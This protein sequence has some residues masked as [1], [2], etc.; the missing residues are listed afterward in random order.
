MSKPVKSIPLIR[1]SGFERT[2][3]RRVQGEVYFDEG[4]LGIYATDASSYQITPVAVCVPKDEQD[5]LAALKTANEFGVTILARGGGT[6][7]AGQA[8]GQSLV[9]DF[10]KHMNKVLEL[11]VEQRWVRVQPGLV[12]D[13]LNALLA[14]HKL[15]YAIDP[16]TANR[17]NIG[18]IVANN[19][20]GTKSILYGKA[21]EHLIA[22]KV[23]L[24]D[25]TVM[26]LRAR[27]MED[28]EV[29]ASQDTREGEIHRG[30]Y[31]IIERNREEIARRW[32]KVMRCVQGYNLNAFIQPG[33]D[34]NLAQL[35][36]GSEG[37]LAT[38]LE[39]TIN[40]EPL[41]KA[42][43]IC[44]P[45]FTSV[46]DAIRAT[47]DILPFNPSAVE[48]LDGYTLQLGYGNL[49]VRRDM[50]WMVGDVPGAVLICEFYGDT[51]ED[52]L[53]RAEAMAASL[54]A[55]GKG[56][57]YPIC[58]AA[59]DQEK[60]WNVRKN[61]L[62]LMMGVKGRRKPMPLI[63][64]AAI[65]VENLADY[66]DK[67]LVILKQRNVDVVL[68]AH[69]SVGVLH[70]RPILDLRDA[71][72]LELMKEISNAVFELVMQYGGAFS[73]EHGDG[74]V[75]S[76]YMERFYGPQ[77]YQA[78]HEVKKLFDPQWRMNPGKKV[79]APPID[80]N[81]RFGTQYDAPEP[82]TIYHYREI[83]SFTEAVHL[84]TGVGACRKTLGGTMCPSYMVTRDEEHSTRGRG[85]I[86]RLAMSGQ[87]GPE[88]MSSDRVYEALDLCL[89]C[90]GCKAEC[91][92]NVDMAKLKSEFLQ[93]YRDKHGIT[94]RDRIIGD[95]PRAAALTAGPLAPFFNWAQELAPIR[96]LLESKAG[97]DRRRPLPRV[98]S[99]TFATWF[100]KR[101]DGLKAPDRPVAL[102]CDTYLN[103]Y[104]PHIGRAAVALLESCGYE[105]QLAEVGCCQRPRISHGLLRQAKA[106]GMNTL[107]GIAQ[108]VARDIPVVAIE[109]SCASALTDD[110]P[111]MAEDEALGSA[112][113]RGV[114]II[115]QFLACEYE[116]GRIAGFKTDQPGI[117]LHGHCHQK[118]LYSTQG[119]T[120]LLE[121]AGVPTREVDSG[122]CGMAG[123]FGYEKEHY[124]LSVRAGER[125]LMPAIRDRAAGTAVVAC[126]FSCR[127]QIR[128]L[129]DT[130]ALHWVE[131]LRGTGRA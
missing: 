23:A 63:E 124:E 95:S 121:A 105:V 26:N 10:S 80:Q 89:S 15:H 75:R 34:W 59:A 117:L 18:G 91:P 79:D 56:H 48:I 103:Y 2:L 58:T 129:T 32:P 67:V 83:G 70:V 19:S 47:V 86:L 55:A 114:K 57:A 41:P 4:T 112:A 35:V 118:A 77:L 50:D 25:G 71:G 42:K 29:R 72:D 93:M 104:E 9:I 60:V 108:Y 44:V 3:R 62:G 94:L 40:L 88:A 99:Q 21:S 6:S 116:A 43:C 130:R 45:H 106:E 51:Q 81:L 85:N 64:D 5:V 84:C 73:G 37:T 27:S 69:A 78:F 109:P 61:G 36:C 92:S 13:E 119:M 11:N 100:R 1:V 53:A 49:S 14:P 90:K 8:V 28:Y 131:V 101:K 7:L 66:I 68:Y 17:A 31:E 102:F 111:D 38:I 123:S 65:P 20:S 12:R 46:T 125:R 113:R 74:L 115:D 30:V 16:A 107:R 22:M 122:C 33:T 110:L 87:L 120:V 52:V 76:P 127:H 82:E 96:K 128:D 98:A 39:I 126:G 54:R 24:A 97:F